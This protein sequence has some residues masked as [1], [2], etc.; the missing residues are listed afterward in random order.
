MCI[1]YG[2]RLPIESKGLKSFA[3]QACRLLAKAF[4]NLY[5]RSVE[6][7]GKEN[8]PTDGGILFSPSHHSGF[9]DPVL[10][11]THLKERFVSLVRSDV[12]GGTYQWFLDAMQTLPIYRIRDGFESLT[13]N[14]EIFGYCMD[15][16]GN[17]GRVLMF[18][19]TTQHNDYSLWPISKGSSRLVYQSQLKYPK[20]KIYLLPVGVNYSHLNNPR[21]R[22][23]LVF[24]KSILVSNFLN[25]GYSIA[26]NI[27]LLKE[28]LQ[29]EM[30][31][32]LWLP[33]RC[34][35]FNLRAKC[36]NAK[37]TKAP[38]REIKRKLADPNI[39][40]TNLQFKNGRKSILFHLLSLPNYIPLFITSRIL[41]L[42]DNRDF[43]N[44]MKYGLGLI[45][46][47]FYWLIIGL[48]CVLL[49]GWLIAFAVTSVCVITVFLRQNMIED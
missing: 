26:Q 45:L 43:Y 29:Q 40:P 46:F 15:V 4:N 22:V 30:K 25:E 38:F 2:N 35:D 37:S 19:E 34:P 12:F 11:V 3:Y 39:E 27:N 10:I 28:T 33:D 13:K 47:P 21:C 16:L 36:I 6:V 48:V 23:Q 8:I 5:F 44:S 24:G 7:Y 1:E 32:C 9:L 41:R 42:F 20:S 17:N 14:H 31:N 18:S 49:F